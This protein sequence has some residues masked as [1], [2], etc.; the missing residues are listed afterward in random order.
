[1]GKS[2]AVYYI[3]HWIAYHGSVSPTLSETSILVQTSHQRALRSLIIYG[4]CEL[5]SLFWSHGLRT[6]KSVTIILWFNKCNGYEYGSYT[7]NVYV[8]GVQSEIMR[9]SIGIF[10][11]LFFFLILHPGLSCSY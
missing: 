3:S 1:M 9:N 5:R 4:P 11:Y 6:C 7:L 8:Q 2:R 10:I